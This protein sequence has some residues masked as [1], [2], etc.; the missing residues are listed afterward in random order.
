MISEVSVIPPSISSLELLDANRIATHILSISPD[1]VLSWGFWEAVRE[2]LQNSID[3]H[4]AN[5][6][7]QKVFDYTEPALIIGNSQCRLEPKTLL[8]GVSDKHGSS[9]M[10][11]QFGE[12]YKLALLVLTRLS[13]NVVILNN[14]TIW[15]PRLVYSDEYESYVLTVSIYRAETP[16]D[17]VHF[18]I[19]DVNQ[20]DFDKVAEN[21]L[22]DNVEMDAI[23]E[24]DHLRKRVFVSGLFVCEI[25]EL[26][27]GYN[28]APGR[29]KLDRDRRLASSFEVSYSAS[30]LWSCHENRALLY[31]NM[32][33][34]VADVQHISW[35][36][37][38]V[39]Q[40]IV[41]RYL[42]EHPGTLPVSSQ[43]DID[44]YQGCKTR[45][46]P[47][48]LKNLLREMHEFAFSRE[49]T[50]LERL[51]RFDRGFRNQLNGEGRRE[52]KAIVEE[53]EEWRKC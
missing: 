33:L 12:G 53:S 32:Q 50:P 15:V 41:N 13:W 35:A 43:E 17:G 10:I 27:Y 36:P 42:S 47:V 39:K 24:E 2:L 21:Y 3:Q 7:S 25:D 45:L 14:D 1:Y 16:I 20:D 49:G 19:R 9:K 52:L 28:F 44:K 6:E 8:L 48:P 40:Y 22:G 18:V 51:T 5:S 38:D 34:G 46:V 37:T 29:I 4:T 23:L 11:G 26:T 30:Q 31:D